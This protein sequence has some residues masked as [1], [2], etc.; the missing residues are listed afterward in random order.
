MKLFGQSEFEQMSNLIKTLCKKVEWL[1]EQLGP[2]KNLLENEYPQE[3]TFE[4]SIANP[5]ASMQFSPRIF[6][7]LCV[8]FLLYFQ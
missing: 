7:C 5:T 2:K 6:Y 3:L 1:T 4:T 8:L